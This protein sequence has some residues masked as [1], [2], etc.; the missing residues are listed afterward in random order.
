MMPTGGPRSIMPS[1]NPKNYRSNYNHSSE[2]AEAGYYSV[3]LPAYEIKAELTV[4]P[5][6]GIHR[7]TY[8]SLKQVIIRCICRPMK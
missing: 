5:H 7:Y 8:Y 4:T 2:I 6:V 1:F 3:Y